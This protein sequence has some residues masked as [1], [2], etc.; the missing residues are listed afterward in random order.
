MILVLDNSVTKDDNLSY[1]DHMIEVLDKYKIKYIRV[2]KIQSL[3]NMEDKIKGI[4]LTGSSM[5]LS[6]LTKNGGLHGYLFNIYYLTKFDVPVYGLCFGCQLLNVIYDGR[7]HDHKKY[8]CDDI[9]FFK[10]DKKNPLLKNVETNTFAYCFSDIPIPSQKL[11]VDVFAN[12][13]IDGKIISCGF[14]FE[15]NKVF[16][17]MFH[18]EL[19]DNTDVVYF[20]FYNICKKYKAK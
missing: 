14:E 20:N 9:P 2:N 11:D 17:T 10:C 7:L 19:H 15:K 18:P 8:I 4:I 13:K 6:K 1:A 12:F 5:K 16:G 3:G